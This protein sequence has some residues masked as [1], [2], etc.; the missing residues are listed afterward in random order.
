MG[1]EIT[2]PWELTIVSVNAHD[3]PDIFF[4]SCAYYILFTTCKNWQFAQ[5]AH[6]TLISDG[7][8]CW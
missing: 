5:M 3:I 2:N 8:V 1:F 6:V 7:H 4:L